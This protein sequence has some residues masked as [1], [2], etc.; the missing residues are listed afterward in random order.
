MSQE[1]LFSETNQHVS[2]PQTEEEFLENLSQGFTEDPV[3]E[4]EEDD[5]AEEDYEDEEEDEEREKEISLNGSSQSLTSPLEGRADIA[6]MVFALQQE[7]K[8][9]T[10][11][12]TH[13]N[14]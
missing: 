1:G 4:E 8:I 9:H 12:H 13:S 5:E 10:H 3:D 11:T 7:G 6:S 2:V 14:M